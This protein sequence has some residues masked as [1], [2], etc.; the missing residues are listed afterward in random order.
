M[1]FRLASFFRSWGAVFLLFTLIAGGLKAQDPR[2]P[3]PTNTLN[4]SSRLVILDA[5]VTDDAGRPVTGLK[6]SDFQIFED[7]APQSI[8]H[9]DP[10]SAAP[11]APSATGGLVQSSADLARLGDRPVTL[12]LLDELNMSFGEE[13]YARQQVER[14]LRAQPP[15]LAEPTLLLALT[16]TDLQV[17]EDTTQSRDKMLAVLHAHT[18]GTPWRYGNVGAIEGAAADAMAET[19]GALDQIAQ[20]TRGLP[21]RKN[22]FWVG[23]GFRSFLATDVNATAAGEVEAHLRLIE[24]ELFRSRVTLSI[25]GNTVRPPNTFTHKQTNS[26]ILGGIVDFAL[27]DSIGTIAFNNLA[28]PTGGKAFAGRNDLAGELTEAA[29]AA[30]SAYTLTYSP[31]DKSDNPRRF[32]KIEVRVLR[33]GLHVQTRSGYFAEP[34]HDPAQPAPK[35][36]HQQLAFDLYGAGLSKISYTDLHVQP[37]R[38]D[39]DHW[40]LRVRATEMGWHSEPDGTRRADDVVLALCFGKNGKLLTRTFHI[41]GANTK[42]SDVQLLGRQIPLDFALQLPPETARVRFVVR[43]GISERVGTADT[44][45]LA[46]PGDTGPAEAAEFHVH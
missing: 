22:L 39:A 23:D 9:F 26:Q 43:D 2:P 34:A 41:V 11:A 3:S 7:R 32:R 10:P 37:A 1:L 40:L 5:A 29:T 36:S 19:L 16:Y 45:P 24:Q 30:R 35:P 28:A 4:V 15:V 38:L 25:I 17:L 6:A 33:P 20:S 8:L 42:A 44:T 27:L 12:I 46:H 13:V 18:A 31:T 21:G 14:W